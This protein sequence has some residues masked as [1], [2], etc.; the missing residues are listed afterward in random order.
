MAMATAAR[1]S[2]DQVARSRH[3]R[4][5][6]AAIVGAVVVLLAAV[7]GGLG[8]WRYAATYAPLSPSGFFGPYGNHASNLVIQPTDIG[9]EIYIKGPA[10][11]EAQ[12]FTGLDN[13][14]SHDV[15]VES[16]PDS[17]LIAN[18]Q[19]APW[20]TPGSAPG[21]EGR[22]PLRSLPAN[23]PAHGRISLVLTLRRPVCTPRGI[24]VST[25]RVL[26]RWHA[27]GVDHQYALLLGFPERMTFVGCPHYLVTPSHH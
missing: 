23:L 24:E 10:G 12:V 9:D 6:I 2:A 20:V 14:G 13:D 5:R 18:V 26:L 16:F 11:T 3:R 15:T 19:W 21:A 17:R 22:L 7:G 1:P 8:F 25:D 4:W 27:L